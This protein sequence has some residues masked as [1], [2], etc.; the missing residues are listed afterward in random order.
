[1]ASFGPTEGRI[2]DTVWETAMEMQVVFEFA[3]AVMTGR[4]EEAVQIPRFAVLTA[5]TMAETLAENE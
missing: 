1:M 3:E 4:R 5:A 2:L